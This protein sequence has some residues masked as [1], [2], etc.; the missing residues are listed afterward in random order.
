MDCANDNRNLK[1][2]LKWSASN[3]NT[4]FLVRYNN[5]KYNTDGIIYTQ[6]KDKHIKVFYWMNLM[7]LIFSVRG[8]NPIRFFSKSLSKIY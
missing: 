4:G 8:T 7:K 6:Y 1:P 2:F 5:L 3:R